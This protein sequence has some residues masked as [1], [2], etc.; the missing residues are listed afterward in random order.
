MNTDKTFHEKLLKVQA[1]IE[2]IKKDSVNPFFHSK[3]FDINSLLA[4]VKPVLN[5]NGLIILQPL[6][7]IEGKNAIHT[8]ITDGAD[9]IEGT[10]ILPEVTDPQKAG[11]NIS[12]FRRYAIQSLLALEAE[13][14]DANASST[15]SKPTL[16]VSKPMA[17]PGPISKPVAPTAAKTTTTTLPVKHYLCPVHGDTVVWREPGI[18]KATKKP[19]A[20]FWACSEKT[21]GKFC[22]EKL[23]EAP[24]P[25]RTDLDEPPFITD[26]EMELQFDKG[27]LPD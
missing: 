17:L 18:N 15:G 27:D 6:I 26:D 24:E 10:I 23:I 13:D 25:E 12:Y 5:Q 3:Y 8:T 1:D 19:Y 2:A 22:K 4:A 20:G 11:S 21:D 16:P 14:D 9:K 7:N